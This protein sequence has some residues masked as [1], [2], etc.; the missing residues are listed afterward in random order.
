MLMNYIIPAYAH[1]MK[2]EYMRQIFF[3]GA[4]KRRKKLIKQQQT[5]EENEMDWRFL[6]R[7]RE[8]L[9]GIK[10]SKT[11]PNNKKKWEEKKTHDC[12]VSNNKTKIHSLLATHIYIHIKIHSQINCWILR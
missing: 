3:F 4:G 8:S 11:K 7:K 6:E 5:L 2:V 1:K 10:S 9:H 12:P